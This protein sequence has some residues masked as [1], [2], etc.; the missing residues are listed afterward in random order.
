MYDG[1]NDERQHK[2]KDG[3]AISNLPLLAFGLIT[4]FGHKFASGLNIAFGRNKLI[5]LN[6]A[7]G[8]KV[9]I[10]LYNV[11]P[12][13][14]IVKSFDLASL[15]SIVGH[16]DIGNISL[17]RSSTLVDCRICNGI[18]RLISNISLIGFI[19]LGLVGLIGFSLISII[20]LFV[21]S[22]SFIC[23]LS[24]ALHNFSAAISAA[25][26]NSWQLVVTHRVA[27]FFAVLHNHNC[28]TTEAAK[29]TQWLKHH[30]GSH[31]AALQISAC[32]IV[33]ATTAYYAASSHHV[34][35][36]CE[37]KDDVLVACA[38]KK[39]YAVVDCLFSQLLSR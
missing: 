24:F 34:G 21:S 13:K 15:V 25:T 6:T 9:L 8:H 30:T 33:N 38:C 1:T 20:G 12:S 3:K 18:D 36:V 7:Y 32:K 39:K 14:L 27:A 22:A 35:S 2:R 11:G 17:V 16:S 23:R 29:T 26:A 19:S 4:A 5:K 31:D 10:D 37:G 28:L